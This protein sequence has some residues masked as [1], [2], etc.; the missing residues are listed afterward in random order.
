MFA[1]ILFFYSDPKV[2]II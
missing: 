1:G 2:I